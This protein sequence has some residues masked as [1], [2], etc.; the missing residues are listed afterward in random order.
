M[1]NDSRITKNQFF[2]NFFKVRVFFNLFCLSERKLRPQRL[3]VINKE[4]KPFEK[5][6]HNSLNLNNFPQGGL[7]LNGGGNCLGQLAQGTIVRGVIVQ[8]AIGIGGNSP[9]GDCLGGNCPGRNCP[10]GY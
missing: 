4:I 10:G 6:F 1:Y 3:N 8:G 9:E 7:Q 5:E 2:C